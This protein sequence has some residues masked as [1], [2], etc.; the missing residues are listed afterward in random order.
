MSM[1]P[2]AP[3]DL[4]RHVEGWL[5]VCALTDITDK[6]GLAIVVKGNDVALMREG[7]AVHALGG[8]CPH[9]GGPIDRKSV[10]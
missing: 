3:R 4:G 10:V 1:N 5:D 2:N 7:D 6:R 8:T 9:R